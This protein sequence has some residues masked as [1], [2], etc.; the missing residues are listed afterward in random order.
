[1]IE[2][3]D[4][5]LK[6]K[7]HI[8]TIYERY[9]KTDRIILKGFANTIRLNLQNFPSTGHFILEFIQNADDASSTKFKLTA[10]DDLVEIE[11]DG[12]SFSKEN[13]ES[14]CNSAMSS[15]NPEFNLG[16]L[17]VGFKSCF[18]ISNCPEI[19]SGYY[20]FKFDKESVNSADLPYELMPIWKDGT[21]MKNGA[22]FR[23][24]LISDER[25][26]NLIGEQLESNSISGKLLLFLRNLSE[27]EI[28][29][30]INDKSIHRKITK[31]DS[32]IKSDS[33]S[34]Y[35]VS[36]EEERGSTINKWIVFQ[37]AYEVPINVRNDELT[38]Q[39]RRENIKK[40][41]VFAA[42]ELGEN[43]EI[44]SEHGTIHFGVYSFL[45]LKD[46][47]STFKF[48]IQG[49][50]LTNPGRSDILREAP[51]NAWVADCIYDLLVNH[52]I[53][54][55]LNKPE[56]R[57][58]V[59]DIFYAENLGNEVVNQR[60]IQPTH[61]FLANNPVVFDFLDNPILP[62]EAISLPNEL[63]E[64]LGSGN[65]KSIFGKV[66]LSPLV[67]YARP[68]GS[69]VIGPDSIPEFLSGREAK[70]LLLDKALIRDLEWFK[71]FYSK[72]ASSITEQ[73]DL[74][75][76]QGIR[77]L[78]SKDYELL[79]PHEVQL[80]TDQTIPESKLSEFKTVHREIYADPRIL[81]F[82]QEK[83]GIQLL[84]MDDIR[85]LD[86]YTP[87][88]WAKQSIDEKIR[89]IRYLKK[90]P[91]KITGKLSYLTLPAKDGGWEVPEKLVFPAEFDPPYK[92]EMLTNKG[93]LHRR[94]PKFVSPM[95]LETWNDNV[96]EWRNFLKEKLGCED[97]E[98]LKDIKEEIGVLSVSF[99]EKE[100]EQRKVE[101]PKEMGL[102]ESPGYDLKSTSGEWDV[103]LIEV[104][105]S[106][107]TYGFDFTM[108]PNEHKALYA[109]RPS[110]EK[111]YVYAVK[112][113]LNSPEINIL[114]GDDIKNLFTRIL[115]NES[116]KEGWSKICKKKVS[117]ITLIPEKPR[118]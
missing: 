47:S 46:I 70:A 41:D 81:T 53:P 111:N 89:F 100:H 67:E 59:C 76:L 96:I 117:V 78:L 5:I 118:K 20:S 90:H 9:Q 69:I 115:V 106:D 43:D 31:K 113:V 71:S 2:L 99:Y 95:L 114:E 73:E 52:C 68:L 51:W 26:K 97:E 98:L 6:A 109:D 27:I 60:I 4:E 25:I 21:T 83:V 57:Y 23:L 74:L 38:R 35:E 33:F 84:T 30:N 93:L 82:L 37:N 75:R 18:K 49:D 107:K 56:W 24:P 36:E 80:V 91:D 61:T 29:A 92:I 116:G 45:P 85:D 88:Q 77:W 65:I 72:L 66:P 34:V 12:S 104:K 101:D 58:K 64:F 32:P 50:F 40:R 19:R 16:Y 63:V 10:T 17:G 112:N 87:E 55:F 39:F 54:A 44:K 13:V 28:N 7:S 108:T 3:N 62:R 102:N 22:Y 110:N 15:K 79:S 11:N 105:S 8:A 14:V 48:I 42:F 1:M 103:R 94:V 86:Q